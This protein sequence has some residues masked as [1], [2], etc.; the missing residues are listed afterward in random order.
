M[1]NNLK[2]IHTHTHI[3][4]PENLKLTQHCKLTIFPTKKQ[5]NKDTEEVFSK[6][7]R[8]GIRL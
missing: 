7:K 2:I 4:W 8:L 1:E 5:L 6:K 3:H